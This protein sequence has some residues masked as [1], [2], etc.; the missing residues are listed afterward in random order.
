MKIGYARVS[1]KDQI[2]D[3]QLDAL[4]NYGC[5]K[6]FKEAVSGAKA[7]RKELNKMLDNIRTGDTVVVHKLDRLGRTL[8]HLVHL[9][10]LFDEKGI[11]FVSLNDPVDTT[12][13]QGR[14][15][16][17]I[18]CSLAEFERELISERTKSG[19]AAAKSRGRLGGRPKG[20]SDEA[21]ATAKMAASLYE[22]QNYS[23]KEICDNLKIS[24]STFYAY[25][26]HQG[27]FKSDTDRV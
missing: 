7:E 5:K 2:F 17:N 1:T 9:V 22:S 15:V 25:L 11:G 10:S 13:A 23:I 14:L 8:K 18:F 3:R 20:L 27:V 12:T 26:R 19:L 6:I 24:S 4:K 16:F 21:K